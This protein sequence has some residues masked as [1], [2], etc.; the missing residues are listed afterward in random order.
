MMTCQHRYSLAAK[1]PA[2]SE[3][4]E[5]NADC[6]DV[7]FGVGIIGKTKQQARLSNTG[8]TD[9]EQL[10]KVIVSISMVRQR[11]SASLGNWVVRRSNQ[12]R[13]DTLEIKIT[14]VKVQHTRRL[15]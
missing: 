4:Y 12:R 10:E 15:V 6:R 13:D 14:S 7:A 9:E 5:V 3:T 11:R 1:Y 8:V 2:A